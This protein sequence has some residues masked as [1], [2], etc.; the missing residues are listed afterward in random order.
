MW[1]T[2]TISAVILW[3]FVNIADNYLVER[4]KK[5]GHPIG[6]LVIFSS[7]FGFIAALG[8]FLAIKGSFVLPVKDIG[9]LLVAGLCNVS[10]IIFYLK[11][12]PDEDVS[13]VIPWFLTSPFFGY[14]LGYF[15]LGENLSQQ[16]LMGGAIILVGGLLLSIKRDENANYAFRWKLIRN[17]TIASLLAALWGILFKFVGRESGFWVSSFWEHIG[18]GIGG[19]MIIFFVPAYRKGFSGIMK[20]DGRQVLSI[21]FFSET[22][23]IIGNLFANYA[24]L[25]VPVSA[26]LLLEVVQPAIVFVLGIFCT[27]FLPKILTEDISWKNLLQKGVSIAIM[28][29]GAVLLT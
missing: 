28:I 5:F 2:L 27:V 20:S 6:A 9:I 21:S 13:T 22:A 19:L 12:L 8:M 14:V 1:I 3:S 25:L 11:A 23:T 15:I 26:V 16:Q 17:M 10:W 18:L 24:I 4:N 7:L 29:A